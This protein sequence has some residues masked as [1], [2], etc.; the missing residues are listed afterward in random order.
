MGNRLSRAAPASGW[1]FLYLTGTALSL[2]LVV[3]VKAAVPGSASSEGFVAAG[4]V[5][6]LYTAISAF[7]YYTSV[8]RAPSRAL[9][10]DEL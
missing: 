4:S 5:V 3:A 7:Y 8:N 6:G 10:A 1:P 2:G 9:P